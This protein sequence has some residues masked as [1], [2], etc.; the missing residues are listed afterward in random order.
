MTDTE[1]TPQGLQAPKEEL[2]VALEAARLAQPLIE[3]DQGRQHVLLPPGYSTKDV[4]HPDIQDLHI[5][6]TVTLDDAASLSTYTNRFS[7]DRSILIADYDSLSI[8]S[9]LDWHNNNDADLLPEPCA[10]V[11][12]LKIRS[13][14]EF[15]RWNSMQGTL[16]DQ[17]EFAEF[18]DENVSD[19][20]DPDPNVFLEIARDLEATQGCQF[21]AGT[22]LQTGE[23][24]FSYETETQVK[25]DFV[26]PQRFT[27]SIPL[28]DGEQ[29]TDIV[30]SFRFKPS[31]KGLGL[32]FVWRRV[33]YVR[34]A[35]F[36][37]IAHR[38]SEETGR[39]VVF[40]R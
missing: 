17:S 24:S 34:R 13:S 23:R 9:H 31:P 5:K 14:E 40:G 20:V 1:T 38:V 10:H 36:K 22:R 19:I 12:T 25:N 21:K 35:M 33:E 27:L 7:D 18:L 37:E 3:L 29:P 6:Q 28:F 32:G 30:A 11:A 26:V 15:E 4:S 16:H 2:Q 39:P 8:R